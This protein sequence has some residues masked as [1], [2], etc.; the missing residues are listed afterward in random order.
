MSGVT[1]TGPSPTNPLNYTVAVNNILPL[2]N[3]VAGGGLTINIDIPIKLTV[4]WSDCS[5]GDD[6]NMA[7][8]E[9][10]GPVELKG[11]H[12]SDMSLS[13]RWILTPL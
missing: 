7:V 13:R 3:V 1:P 4:F 8:G 2:N 6:Y 11:V 5:Q 12:V 10:I 9:S